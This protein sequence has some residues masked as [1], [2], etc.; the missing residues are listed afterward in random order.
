MQSIKCEKEY[1]AN[2]LY[3]QDLD[4]SHYDTLVGGDEPCDVYKPD[5]TT[6]LKYRPGWFSNQLCESV[7][8][9][10]RKAA[11][12]TT[13]RGI[14]SGTVKE[15]VTHTSSVT[16]SGRKSN[17]HHAKP[18]TSSIIGYFDRNP[19]FPYC[20]QTAFLIKEAAAWKS[21]LPYIVRADEGFQELMPE[22][23]QRQKKIVDKTPEDWVIKDS[24]FT[25]VTVNRNWATSC[26]QDKGDYKQGFGVMSCLRNEKYEGGY[27][28]FPQYRVAVDFGHGSLVLADVHSWHGNTQFTNMRPAYERITMVF[29]YREKMVQ[30]LPTKEEIEFAKNRKRGEALDP[31]K[32]L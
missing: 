1:E 8:G 2:N 6:L 31:S 28:V 12:P 11:S 32:R 9:S 24:T 15:G 3:G 18:V 29:Y 17:T 20:R 25:T 16:K 5:G 7:I 30:C 21:F 10:C 14:A 23:W 22:Q 19:R 13:N 27:L 26:H 4:E